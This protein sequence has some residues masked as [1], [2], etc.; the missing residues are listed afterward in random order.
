MSQKAPDEEV[1]QS[2]LD[3]VTEGTYPASE[4]VISSGFPSSALSKELDLL[5]KARE[6]VEV[7]PSQTLD[8]ELLV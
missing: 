1:C 3:F 2:L 7:S 4:N 6:Q 5:S 8:Q